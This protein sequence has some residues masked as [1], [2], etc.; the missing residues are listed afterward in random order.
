[1]T[2]PA[3]PYNESFYSLKYEDGNKT[4]AFTIEG[5]RN[6]SDVLADIQLFLQATG[7]CFHPGDELQLVDFQE[8]QYQRDRE[9]DGAD[10]DGWE[11]EEKTENWQADGQQWQN[12]GWSEVDGPIE[13]PFNGTKE[14]DFSK[15]LLKDDKPF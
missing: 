12:N 10:L 1:M 4:I 5:G 6:L 11:E 8:V 15:S 7:Y 9:W 2:D 14:S 13:F 3:Y